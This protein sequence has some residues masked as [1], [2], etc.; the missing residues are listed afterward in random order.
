M[1]QISTL[2]LVRRPKLELLVLQPTPLCNLDCTY[3]YLPNRRSRARMAPEVLEAA[4]RRAVESP[5]LGEELTVVW[6]AGEPLV[7]APD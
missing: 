5:F 4:I 7:L 3:C 2:R 1:I 6:H